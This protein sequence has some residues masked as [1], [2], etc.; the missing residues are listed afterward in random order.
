MLLRNNSSVAA[1]WTLEER[2]GGGGAGQGAEASG[3]GGGGGGGGEITFSMTSGELPPLGEVEVECFLAPS[4][5]G[6]YRS[7]IVCTAGGGRAS[8]VAA[9]AD[10]LQPRAVLSEVEVDLGVCYIGAAV[11]RQLTVQNMTML[12]AVRPHRY[13]SPCH[14]IPFNSSIE[15]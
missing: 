9:R 7:I 12:P 15:G 10:V 13:C 8:C 6:P 11:E 5:P 3:D 1:A 2:R 14:R 4:E